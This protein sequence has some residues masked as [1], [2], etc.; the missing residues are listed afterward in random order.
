MTKSEALKHLAGRKLYFETIKEYDR[1]NKIAEIMDNVS[2]MPREKDFSIYKTVGLHI[3]KQ[4]VEGECERCSDYYKPFE[5]PKENMITAW[6]EK[7]GDPE[8]E[9]EVERQAKELDGY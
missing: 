1:A 2:R 7:Y 5:F 9:A 3:K 6:L 8:I 4:I